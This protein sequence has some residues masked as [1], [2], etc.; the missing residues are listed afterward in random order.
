VFLITNDKNLVNKSC[1]CKINASNFNGLKINILNWI[2]KDKLSTVLYKPA[3]PT[4]FNINNN[5][6]PILFNYKQLNVFIDKI[7]SFAID[8]N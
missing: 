3:S 5:N 2:N 1:I 4:H 6:N 8:S 7:V